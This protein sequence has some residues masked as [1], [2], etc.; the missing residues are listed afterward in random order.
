M[1][2]GFYTKILK[3][4]AFQIDPE[5]IH[6]LALKLGSIL[7]KFWI[8]RTIISALYNYS[9]KRL[10]TKVLGI[11]FK[12]PL[13]LAAGFDKNAKITDI[14]PSVGFGFMEVGSITALKCEGNPKPR[15]WRLPKDNSIAVYFGLANDGAE[16]ISKKLK[17]KSFE[18]P[19]A[20]SIA[21]TNDSKIKGDASVE[22]YYKSYLLTK[23]IADFIVLNISC[24]NTGDGCSFENPLLLDKLLKRINNKNKIT[25]LKISSALERKQ[26]DQIIKVVDKYKISGFIISNLN[27]S[28]SNLK[29]S[30]EELDK[31]KGGLSGEPVRE[32]SNKLIKYIYK[33]TKGGYII[34]GLG[35]IFTAEDAYEKI[36]NGA[37]LVQLITGMI[38]KG[39]GVIKEI[40]KGLVRLLEADG[41]SNISKAV[42]MNN[43]VD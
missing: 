17:N 3:P 41:Y 30:K 28:K 38:Y 23:D 25:F 12:N 1:D 18:I 15:L 24:P 32:P 6:N 21:K 29:S 20:I 11:N 8:S 26:V 39:P 40:N 42:G 13:G 31:V 35:G 36:K 10:E 43:F 5:E 2:M 16:A 34:I 19:L 33:K 37:S 9:N 22:D 27:K 7:G 4:I 14:L